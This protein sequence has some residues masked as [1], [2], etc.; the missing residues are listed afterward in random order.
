MLELECK[1][2]NSVII[3]GKDALLWVDPLSSPQTY[4]PPKGPVAYLATEQ[5]FL[6]ESNDDMLCLE[7]PGEYETG[8]FWI[9][10]VAAQRHL[11]TPEQPKQATIYRVRAGEFRIA[12]LGNID[13]VLSEDQ[14]EVLG[15]VD[16]LII[17][18][19]GGGYTLDATAAAKLVRQIEPSIA[20]PVHYA[21]QGATYEVPQ[22]TVD[23]FIHELGAPVEAMPKIK[24]K[25]TTALPQVLSVYRLG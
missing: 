6:P 8:P 7:G 9:T 25:N 5:R 4:K 17:P 21:E 12:V 20:V 10:G 1:G 16:I 3:A 24:M 13:P 11:D 18:V 2:A 22:D 23:T 14:L 19:G 15:T